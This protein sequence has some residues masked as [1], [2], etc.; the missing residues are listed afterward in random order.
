[1]R[2]SVCIT[3]F[4]GEKYIEEQIRSII[5]QL[6]HHDEVIVCDDGSTDAT[7]A[8]LAEID[9]PRI[10]IEKNISSLGVVKNFNKSLQFARN[11]IV[12]LSDQ[13]DIWLPSKVNK[14]TEVFYENPEITLVTSDAQIIDGD[15]LILDLSFFSKRGKFTANPI[16]NLIKNKHLGCTLAFRREMLDLFLPF[17]ED[18]PM[19]DIWIG[20]INGIYGKAYFIEESLIQ[21][22]RHNMNV[23]S[24]THAGFLKMLTWRLIICKNLLKT[25]FTHRI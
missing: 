7:L 25:I 15:G 3:T 4:N 9:D 14:F 21:Y 12:F 24:S 16:S 20:L 17:P 5:T 10:R 2:K 22:R 6:D 8:I 11:E 23:S 13:D 18:T 19:H 1:M